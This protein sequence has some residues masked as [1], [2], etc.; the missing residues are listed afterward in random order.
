VAVWIALLRGI[1]V[2]GHRKVR[3]AELRAL[4]ET[5][6]LEEA[7]TYV[8]SGNLVFR[9]SERARAAIEARLAGALAERFGFDVGVVARTLSDWEGAITANPFPEAASAPKTLHAFFL[10][11]PADA[12]AN[13]RLN[14]YSRTDER[15][16]IV[17]DTLYLLTPSGIGRSKFA[18]AAERLVGVPATARNWNSVLN[19]AE[20][21]RA[22]A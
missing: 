11:R 4:A 20:M 2:G 16:E 10:A 15:F 1:N 21:A 3:M 7:R 17:G 13:G 22:I 12:G 18:A 19:I 8:Q 9:S 6:G 14:E 5:L